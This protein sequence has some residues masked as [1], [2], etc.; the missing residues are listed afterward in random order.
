MVNYLLKLLYLLSFALIVIFTYY[1]KDFS[2]HIE[3]FDGGYLNYII[4]IL[5]F[6]FIYKSLN[7]ISGN[8]KIIFTPLKI[9]GYFLLQLFILSILF[10]TLNNESG[11]L[12]ITLFF[13]IIGF[14]FIPVLIIFGS[15]SFGRFILNKINGFQSESH[16]F[17]FL[18]SIGI[19]FFIFNTLLAIFGFLGFYNL[20]SVSGIL[21]IIIGIS[22]KE[23][24][25]LI[26]S[27]YSYKIEVENHNFNEN[28]S[29]IQN[30]NPF[31][32]TSEFLFIFISFLISVN[33]IN[34]LRPMPIGWD[35]LGV[36][37]NFPNLMAA[38]GKI[39]PLGMVSWQTFTGIGYM[40]GSA[41][42]SF[43]L[44]NVG[45]VMSVLVII[46]SFYDLLKSKFK[47]FINIPLLSGAIF[48]SMPMIIFQQAKDMK[49]DPGL[50]FISAIIIYLVIYIFTKYLGWTDKIEQS[51][52]EIIEENS[53]NKKSFEV[54]IEN[55]T[56]NGFFSYFSK[57]TH[58]GETDIF[59]NKSYLIYLLLIGVLAGFA[60]S[61]KVTT[62]LLISGILGILFYSKL[63]MAGFISY[64][65]IYV[66]I[67]TKAGLWDM[68]FVVYPKDDM[69]FRNKFFIYSFLFGIILLAYSIYKYSLKSFKNL[70][71]L[72]LLFLVGVGVGVSPWGIKNIVSLNGEK[73]TIGGIL[74]GKGESFNLD[75]TKIYTQVEIDEINKKNDTS[76]TINASGTTTNEDMGRYFGYEKG[77]NNYIK[78]PYN[79][80]MQANQKGEFTDI[81]FIFLAL[82]PAII[83][84]LA[85]K[86]ELLSLGVFA[87]SLIPLGFFFNPKIGEYMTN[88]FTKFELPSGYIILALFFFIP[89]LYI[90]YS[91]NREKYSIL[92]KL[93][94]VFAVFYI[95]LWTISAFGI[96]W[97]GVAMYY[98]LL[99][100]IAIG[101]YYISS[102]SNKNSQKELII[103]F[104]GSLIVFFIVLV[105]FFNSS[106]PHGFTNL[107]TASY[108]NYKAGITNNYISIF[109]SHS[110][111]YDA[112]VELNI[113]PEKRVDLVKYIISKIK[114]DKIK[115]IIIQNNINDLIKLN[116]ALKELSNYDEK[117]QN[118]E[119]IEVRKQSKDL[120][121]ELYK[122]VLYPTKEY[123][124]ELGIY[125]IGTFLKYFIA[126]NNKRLL[127]DSMVTE[128]GKFIY[129]KDNFDIGVDRMKKLGVNYFLVDLNAATIDRDPRHDLTARFENLLKTFTSSKLELVQTDSTC[130]KIALEDYTKSSKTKEDLDKYIRFAGV[131]YESYTSSGETINRGVKQF[132]CYNYILD[133][134]K[135]NKVD[136][137]NY[138]YL[139]PIKQYIDKNNI[140]SD[141]LSDFFR[142]YVGYGWM[143]LFR[144]K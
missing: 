38:S 80:T 134:I 12:G 2:F 111:Y 61:I 28:A 48:L 27:V 15:I 52:I 36:Y 86:F 13:K 8:K 79:L 109:D 139:L 113:K 18:F 4:P 121:S 98:S 21:F 124:N 24:I 106:F 49:L 45:G 44:N 60:F 84:F 25:S 11:A 125:R 29:F 33:F 46:L 65:S 90:M 94:L 105:Y 97:Y 83:L 56:S 92:F 59:S 1:S 19:G 128:F 143:V 58:I 42:Q 55:K 96:V 87:L 40:F 131:N 53:Q 16:I 23:F 3:S 34:I 129:N 126:D 120:K 63:G 71:I 127:D 140:P 43:F 31:L 144:I 82:I 115:N 114:N 136:E 6:Y 22:Y 41:T 108:D 62:L 68:M 7:Y 54:K 14:L 102:Y 76:L 88:I 26:I 51:G 137:K 9:F 123:K 100:A 101:A 89:F 104:S 99:F 32:L 122:N 91:L 116:L 93:N 50:F 119:L 66:G 73:I 67:F 47:T 57:Y 70:I 117:N 133:L 107:K 30:I 112:L 103:K 118:I 17:Q 81:T 77:I 20:Y 74:G 95:F 5:M 78:L 141:Q 75:Y 135:N 10:F 138:S 72:T 64:I 85:F 130:L 39:L 132:G 69:E 35:D 110:D 37:M 142:N